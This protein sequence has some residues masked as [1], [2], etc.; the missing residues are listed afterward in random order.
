[1]REF[2]TWSVSVTQRTT[3]KIAYG[4]L[5]LKEGKSTAARVFS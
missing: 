4:T 5:T 1:M 3:R 2:L